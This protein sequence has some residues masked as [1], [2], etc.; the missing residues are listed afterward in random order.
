V[1]KLSHIPY[2]FACLLQTDMD[3]DPA[4]QFDADADPDATFQYDADPCGSG[5]KHWP[6][7]YDK[8]FWLALI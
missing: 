5:S 6:E 1:L 2:I 7:W 4:Y 3:P 8:Y